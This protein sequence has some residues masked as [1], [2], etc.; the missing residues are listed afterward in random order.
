MRE[1]AAEAGVSLSTASR[2]ARGAAGVDPAV[3]RRVIATIARLRYEPDAAARSIRTGQSRAVGF[4]VADIG[5]PYFATVCKG[6][7]SVLQEHGY[8]LLLVDSDGDPVR[9]Q[10]AVSSLLARRVDGLILSVASERAEYLPGAIRS[11]PTVLVDR[12]LDGISTSTVLSDHAPGVRAAVAHLVGLGHRRITMLAGHTDQYG[13]RARV[14]AFAKA[15]TVH[16]VPD[17]G[18]VA[19]TG[20]AGLA[21]AREV[22]R[23]VLT[24]PNRP[25]AIVVASNDLLVATLETV[26]E[27][28][29]ELPTDLSFVACEDFDVCRL[30]RPPL[31]VI[32]RDVFEVGTRAAQ[33]LVDVLR[34]PPPPG[35]E[36]TIELPTAFVVRGSTGPPAG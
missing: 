11:L 6:V 20:V 14:E 18:A 34:V 12:R 22:A 3:R 2:V 31:A 33:L 5:N 26:H 17:G 30:H 28:A 7:E 25:S 29:I 27:L 4:V 1:V 21:E 36:A 16:G 32:R 24:A 15:A 13:T 35:T 23:E 19:R 8:S 9:E 10:V